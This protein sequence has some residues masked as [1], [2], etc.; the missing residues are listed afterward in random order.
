MVL[1]T[2]ARLRLTSRLLPVLVGVLFAVQ[3]LAPYDGWLVL[4]SGLGGAWLF[5]TLWARSLARHLRLQ[6]EM[7]F[8]WAQVGDRIEERFTLVNHG[9]APGL[10]VE[11]V[12]H[13]DMPGYQISRATAV[14]S[15]AENRWHTGAECTSRGLFTLGPTLVQA[16]DPLGIYTVEIQDPARASLLVTP[17]IVP[18]PT[19]EVAP[20]RHSGR[21]RPRPDAPER[22]VG[23]AGVRP[24]SP[25]DSLRWI[26]WPTVA[27]R[28][29][30]YVRLFEG[31]PAGDWWVVLDDDLHY[32]LGEGQDS[33][34]EHGVI[35]A[36]SMADRGLRLHKAVGLAVNGKELI[37]LPPREGDAQRWEVLRSLA[38]A[39]PGERSLDKM[40]TRL[41]SSFSGQT[42]LILITANPEVGWIEQLLPL[43]WKGAV[44]TV[45]LLDL[46][47]FGSTRSMQPAARQL[48]QLGITHSIIPR[49]LL[50]RTDTQPGRRGRWQ[51]KTTPFGRAVA[52][53]QPQDLRWR[54]L[55]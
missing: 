53:E 51:W 7:R 20:G 4:L 35:L 16:G 5:S 15:W 33:T 1:E 42:S 52:I 13:T 21:G 8:G 12:D 45:L 44:P 23:A 49:E 47:T 25:G 32:R 39:A 29:A 40:L 27:R 6:R 43:L 41:F 48:T 30:F 55:S 34:E 9:W 17:P 18:L 31:T 26:H 11:V 46:Q 14:G 19:I 54:D 36:A 37:W 3:I 10:W 38:L 50:L 2:R 24:Y 28:D 22:T